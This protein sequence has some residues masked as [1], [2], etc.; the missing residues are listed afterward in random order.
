[1][2][3]VTVST[4]AAELEPLRGYLRRAGGEVDLFILD[5]LIELARIQ[6]SE[7]VARRAVLDHEPTTH[8]RRSDD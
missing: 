2:S 8:G 6:E 3:S 4:L 1:M 7:L 5:Q